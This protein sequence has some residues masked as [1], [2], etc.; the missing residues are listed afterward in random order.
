MNKKILFVRTAANDF[1]P[2]TY[3]VQGFGL[4]KAFCK[5]GYDFDYLCFT[6][7]EEKEYVL[8]EINGHKLKV[9]MIFSFGTISPK[10]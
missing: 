5:L 7:K 9:I 2:N 4:G 8:E 1:N 3:N 6:S 10:L